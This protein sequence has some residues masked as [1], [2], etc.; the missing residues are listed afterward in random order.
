[1]RP[2]RLIL[3]L[4]FLSCA[5]FSQSPHPAWQQ[6]NTNHGLPSPEVHYC[7]QD[8]AGFM[9]F[10]TDN[11]LSRF[12]GVRFKNYSLQQGL[13]DPVVF[14]L[15]LD[16]LGR[17]WMSTLSGNL[18]Y[19][20][21]DSIY[22]FI[23]N[24]L[25]QKYKSTN[26]YGY[27][28]IDPGNQFIVSFP[29]IGILRFK[30]NGSH[31]LIN[32]SGHNYENFLFQSAGRWYSGYTR[33]MQ[34]EKSSHTSSPARTDILLLSLI[35]DD[36]NVVLPD[37]LHRGT[38]SFVVTL[39][40][41][42]P[43]GELLF[44]LS[45]TLYE[46]NN[47][48]IQSRRA[49]KNG[50]AIQKT[51][52]PCRDGSILIGDTYDGLF[53]YAD[54]ED[55][56]QQ[57]AA[58]WLPGKAISS[59]FLDRD[60]GLWVSTLENGVF[61]CPDLNLKIYDQ[62]TGLPDNNISALCIGEKG[63]LFVG[64]RKGKVFKLNTRQENITILPDLSKKY[65]VFDMVYFNEDGS[66]WLSCP[67]NYYLS[68]N[69]WHS[70]YD[71]KRGKITAIGKRISL[72]QKTGHLWGGS[73]SQFTQIDARKKAV[74]LK[75]DSLNLKGRT[76]AVYE[77]T[78]GRVWIG[79]T[80]GLL[81][82]RDNELHKPSPFF[83]Q[84]NT[85]VDDLAE[86]SDGTLVIATKGNGVLLWKDSLLQQFS[87]EEGMT[88]DMPEN[89]FVDDKDRIWAGTLTG[90]N[91]LQ[92]NQ[93]GNWEVSNYTIA[94]GLPSNVITDVRTQ[95]NE[96]WV[97]TDNGLANF[98][99]DNLVRS[100]SIAPIITSAY[101]D[102]RAMK[103]DGKDQ[104]SFWENNVSIHFVTLNYKLL[105]KILYRFRVDNGQWQT[106]TNTTVNFPSLPP[107]I[108]RFE[109]QSK[110]EDGIWSKSASL[111][112]YIAPPWWETWWA[113]S[114][115]TL[116]IALL[117]LGYYKYRTDQLKKE[118]RVQKHLTE[119]E[120]QTLRSQMNP[121]FIFNSLNA[122]QG[123]I[124]TGDKREANRYLSRF[125]KLIRSA[126]QHSRMT[127]VP[128]ADDISSLKR[129]LELEQLR[130][131]D[132]FGYEI[133]IDEKINAEDIEIPPLLVQPFVENAIIHGIANK[134]GKGFVSLNYSLDE[135][136]L[137]VTITDNG[138]GIE[139]SK[140]LKSNVVS[141]HKSIGMTVTSRRLEMLSVNGDGKRINIEELK[142]ENGTVT[143]TQVTVN[144]PLEG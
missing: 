64:L 104:L 40:E 73:H 87:L 3:I 130:F 37:T 105:G 122:I 13:N 142:D 57:R 71:P 144:I 53:K 59:V 137:I 66:L 22:P 127:K 112:F 62:S 80:E 11:G 24:D 116:G 67:Q 117:I 19:L 76:F 101:A 92:K 121:H 51:I 136:S 30:P 106:T 95:G 99:L 98:T 91:L 65:I 6:Y 39:A 88:S 7:I 97:A 27:F 111:S 110:N 35:T 70:V 45:D 120:R 72:Q 63:E 79:R 74:T 54:W 23:Y 33:K 140:K 85:R 34:T 26:S 5:G 82:F 141:A 78:G 131:G 58:K 128:L 133:K 129:Y 15:Q 55:V 93:L 42:L 138:I 89:L 143:G 46:I 20:E 118:L 100:A 50:R 107:G 96:V 103:L 1:M 60:G 84:F 12:D 18:Y 109:V 4:M 48:R 77:T 38:R 108:R 126:L 8:S 75:S 94:H 36:S 16:S 2:L 61:Y 9:W 28:S 25:I 69:T 102:N 123:Y 83:Q 47:G 90:L 115:A 114:G 10:A 17:L 41:E 113:I 52:L 124:A 29:G 49:M 139:A 68:N 14:D 43:G 31:E 44:Q 86:L 135:H 134:E 21:N 132:K 56:K 81:E 119:L 125:A 32:R